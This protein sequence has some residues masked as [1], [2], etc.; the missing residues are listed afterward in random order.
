MSAPT[1]QRWLAESIVVFIGYFVTGYAVVHL[2]TGMGGANL[3]W[4]PAGIA[5]A[6][7]LI[8]GIPALPSVALAA[9][10]FNFYI[11]YPGG[12]S[13]LQALAGAIVMAG[14]STVQAWAT[15]W[16]L[17]RRIPSLQVV[18]V[19]HALIFIL[20]TALGCTIA[21]TV[22]TTALARG[23]LGTDATA[24]TWLTWL[25]WW[26]GDLSGMLIVTPVVLVV[27][28]WRKGRREWSLLSLPIIGIGCSFTLVSAF[29]VKHLDHDARVNEF[30]SSGVAMG[31]A[32]QRRVEISQRDLMALHALFY[33]NMP[34]REEFH[35]FSKELLADND[36]IRTLTWSP[37]VSHAQR[38]RFE[39]EIRRTG[40][41][42][43]A[44]YERD[45]SGKRIP[46]PERA[47]YL[48]MLMVEPSGQQVLGFNLLSDPIRR[49]ALALSRFTAEPRAS[50]QLHLIRGG[51]A[52]IIFWPM[53]R[54]EFTLT[55]D[56]RDTDALLGF[57]SMG[58]EIG[59]L[60]SETLRPF[61]TREAES[62]LFDIS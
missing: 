13:I 46:A 15:A 62:W 19:P 31:Q 6:A 54:N 37:Y 24:L 21:A 20:C 41:D 30:M 4:L 61:E 32:L 2:Q 45:E 39:A 55:R 9:L 48:P 44:I 51:Q 40:L 57:V 10:C 12:A 36:L 49:E 3:L 50:G 22:G 29:I 27:M 43:Y 60:A 18:T 56:S 47:E 33:N 8:R 7:A 11:L 28:H 35:N 14:G 16:L 26:V 23:V 5:L 42:S 1:L 52:I 34:S 17:Q 38:A 25:T 59:R 58:L 53:Y